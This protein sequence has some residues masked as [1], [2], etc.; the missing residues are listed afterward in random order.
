MKNHKWKYSAQCVTPGSGRHHGV[1]E[2]WTCTHCG[3]QKSRG[4]QSTHTGARVIR[5]TFRD[6]RGDSVSS[7]PSCE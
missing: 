7:L 6:S 4:P 5:W 2:C 1:D 3:A